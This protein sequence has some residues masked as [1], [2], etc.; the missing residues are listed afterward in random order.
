MHASS[1]FSM[2]KK[3]AVYTS[4]VYTKSKGSFEAVK[5]RDIYDQPLTSSTEESII[6]DISYQDFEE[7]SDSNSESDFAE[8]GEKKGLDRISRCNSH[9]QEDEK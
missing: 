1:S 4:E 3:R 9:H 5:N 8:E 7:N 2:P 6:S